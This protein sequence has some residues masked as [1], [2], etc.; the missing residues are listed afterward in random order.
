MLANSD[1]DNV[2]TAAQAGAQRGYRLLPLLLGRT[3]E[4]EIY[5]R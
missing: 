1:A 5:A 4:R 3:Q 2:V